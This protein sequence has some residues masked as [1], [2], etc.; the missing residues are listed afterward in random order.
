MPTTILDYEALPEPVRRAV[1]VHRNHALADAYRPPAALPVAASYTAQTEAVPAP[2]PAPI[3]TPPPSATAPDLPTETLTAMVD[4]QDR[5]G[6]LRA[7]SGRATS[8][9]LPLQAAEIRRW[10]LRSGD[11]IEA[12]VN[13]DPQP[14]APTIQRIVTL[15]AQPYRTTAL[16]P[17]FDDLAADHPATRITLETQRE[18]LAPRL[19]DIFVPLGFG[20]RTL[21][22]SPPKAGKTTLLRQ[23]GKAI[24]AN[25]PEVPLFLLLIGE[26]PEEISE[27]SREI[28]TATIFASSFDGT[29]HDHAR[30]ARLAV[31]RAK[32]LAEEG[33]DAVVLFD[34]A[35]RLVNAQ[36]LQADGYGSKT[37]SG[38]IDSKAL[39]DTR[40]LF[41]TARKL[42]TAGS[43]TIVATCLIETGSRADDMIFQQLKGTGNMDIYLSRYLAEAEV[44][45]AIDLLQSN[46]R[47]A[48]LL[49][50]ADT[51]A[52]AKLIRE[53]LSSMPYPDRGS[54]EII[55][56]YKRLNATLRSQPSNTAYVQRILENAPSA[57]RAR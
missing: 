48:H 19:L 42:N 54:R 24:A 9:D 12:T 28:P 15:N 37:L 11:L 17:P 36:S 41:G 7:P 40:N 13:L 46:T 2:H 22:V 5:S 52:A 39:T 49:L 27:F 57:A 53:H 3:D 25:Y 29:V 44:F 30:L 47:N 4:L 16:R 45:P 32:R 55:E 33:Q 1:G 51:Q 23:I 8:Q 31:E 14:G 34:S 50:D 18:P 21:V 10:H 6:F 20:Q 26:R 38:G 43:V 56:A 35:T